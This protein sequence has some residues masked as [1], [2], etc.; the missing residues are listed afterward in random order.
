MCEC[1]KNICHITVSTIHVVL[2]F[3]SVLPEYNYVCIVSLCVCLC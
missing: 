3:L 1:L 2:I